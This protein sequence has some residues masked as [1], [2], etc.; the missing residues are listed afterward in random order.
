M[1]EWETCKSL[2]RSYSEIPLKKMLPDPTMVRM[3]NV[4]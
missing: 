2:F 4:S 1:E 3:G